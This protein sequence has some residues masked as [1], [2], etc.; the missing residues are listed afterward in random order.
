VESIGENGLTRAEAMD[1]AAQL[2][3]EG[4]VLYGARVA[5]IRDPEDE[6]TA[7]GIIVPD[8]ARSKPLRGTV[9]MV[10]AGAEIDDEG[11]ATGIHVGDRCTFSKYFNTLFELPLIDGTKVYV[12]V[13]PLND[14]YI[15]WRH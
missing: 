7:S 6:K 5:I 8:Q 10:G 13:V 9:V 14:I 11:A 2:Q 12:E 3:A 1:A 15:G 4:F